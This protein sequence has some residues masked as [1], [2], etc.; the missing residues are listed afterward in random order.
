MASAASLVPE[1][2]AVP[3]PP[4]AVPGCASDVRG[5]TERAG[6]STPPVFAC[7]DPRGRA[8]AGT[9]RWEGGPELVM[10]VKVAGIFPVGSGCRIAVFAPR[11][12]V[13]GCCREPHCTR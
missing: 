7:L 1:K 11:L 12:R 9:V 4:V 2:P 3:P 8:R 13:L 6:H 10:H 5:F